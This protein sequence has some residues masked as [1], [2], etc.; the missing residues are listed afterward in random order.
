MTSRTLHLGV[1]LGEPLLQ[2]SF[3]FT[4]CI[5]C[6]PCFTRNPMVTDVHSKDESHASDA[7]IPNE[8]GI[9]Y[10]HPLFAAQALWEEAIFARPVPCRS[11]NSWGAVLPTPL[12][13][14]PGV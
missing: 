6:W 13:R 4:L 3:I 12:T 10:S 9:D 14:R 8:A 7:C 2:M 11:R 1:F 5:E